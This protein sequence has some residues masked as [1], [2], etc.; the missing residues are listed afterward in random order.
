MGT[1]SMSVPIATSAGRA[2]FGPQLSLTYDSGA[3]NSAFGFGWNLQLPGVTRKT[4]KGLPQYRDAD[5]SDVFI[6]SGAE[7]LVPVYRRDLDGSWT[8]SHGGYQRDDDDWAHDPQ[9]NFVFHEDDLDGYRVRRYCPRIGGLFARIERWSRIGDVSDVHWRSISRDNVLTIYGGDAGSRIFDPDRPDRIFS[10]LACETRDDKGN[11]V[12]YR[13]REEDGGGVGLGRV[14]ERNRGSRDDVRRRANRFI[15]RIHYGNRTTLLDSAGRRPRF[16]DQQQINRQI[17]DGKWMFEVVFDYGDHDPD[18]P[19]PLDNELTKADGTP[20]FPWNFRQDPFSSYRSGFEVRTTRLCRRVLMFHHFADEPVG[21]E[22][23]VRSTDFAYSAAEDPSG[24]SHPVYT[25]LRSVTQT[26]YLRENGAYRSQGLPP[27]E[28]DYTQAVI[29]E[30]VSEVDAAS[31]K[32]LPAGLDDKL[33]RWTDL[34]GEG[35]PGILTEQGGAWF[36]KR[37][38]SPVADGAVELAPLECVTSKP[39]LGLSRDSAQFMDLAGDGQPDLVVFEGPVQG[40]YEHDEDDNGWQSFRPFQS[41]LNRD[42]RDRNLRFVDL[43][44]DGHADVLIT[45]DGAFV[46]HES[47]AERGFGPARRVAQESDEE[48]GPRLVFADGTESI[49]LADLSGDGLSDLVRIRNGEVCYWPNLGYCRFGAKVTMDNAP[50]FDNPEQFDHSRLRLADIDGS[51]TTD[52]IYLH[53]EGVR[54]HFNQSG[55]GWSEPRALQIAP[56]VDDLVNL[57]PADLFGNGT[58]CLVWSSPLPGD[59]PGQMRYVDLMGGQKPHLL[60]VTRNNLGATTEVQYASSTKFYLQDRLAGKPWVTRLAFP[61]HVVEKA[62]VTDVWRNTTFTTTYSYHHGYF[63]GIERE[64]RGFGRVEQIDTEDYGTVAANNAGSPYVSDATLFQPPVK[65]VSWFHT[66]AFLDGERILSQFAHEYFQNPLEAGLPEPDLVSVGRSHQEWREALRSCKGM[67]LRQEVYELDVQALGAGEQRPV[68]LFSAAFH[69]CHIER[70]Q[71]RA[72]NRHAVFLVTESE[73]I[74]YHYE[75]DLTTPTTPDPRATH[76]LN[77]KVDELGQVLQSVAVRYPRFKQFSDAQLSNGT[78]QLIRDVQKELHIAYVETRYTDADIDDPDTYRLRVPCEVQT[79]ELTG[80]GTEDA[81]DG[82]TPDPRDNLYFSIDELRAY[83]LSRRYQ[84][85]GTPVSFLKYH[86]LPDGSPQKRIVEHTRTLYFDDA[87]LAPA[88]AL[89]FGQHGPRGL[90]YEDY[91]LALTKDL[92]AKVFGGRLSESPIPQRTA[93]DLLNDPAV[94]GYW[95]GENFVDKLRD[96][97]WMRSGIAGFAPNAWRHFFLPE[98]YTDP[99]G[100]PTTVSFDTYD[101]LV[102]S[103]QDARDNEV[104][105]VEFDF[106]VLAPAAVRDV[107]ENVTRVAFDIL[108]MPVAMA[109]EAGGDTLGGLTTDLLNPSVLERAT[110]FGLD[111]Y[112]D[113]KPRTWLAQAT[114]RFVYHFGEAVNAFGLVTGWESRPPA[115]C[116]IQRETHVASLNGGKT[117]IQVAVEYSDGMG[118]ILVRKAQ[119]EPDSDSPLQDPPLQWVASG[120]QILNN[121]GKPVK[122]YEPSFSSTEH[123]FDRTEAQQDAG[124]TSITY[125]DAPGRP[126]RVEMPDGTFSRTE[127]S[128]WFVRNFDANDTVSQS[129][130]YRDLGSPAAGAA[131]PADPGMRAAWLALAHDATPS[132]THFDSMGRDVIAIQYNRVEDPASPVVIAG[133]HWRDE[134]YVTFTRFD[135]EGKALWIRDARGH[136][137]MQYISPAKANN[138]PSNDI[139]PGTVPC[140]DV[141]GN[142]LYQYSMDAGER[143]LLSDAAGKPMIAWDRNDQGSGSAKQNR[144]LYTAYDELHRPTAQ[145]ISIDRSPAQQAER[146]EYR[147]ADDGDAAALRNNLQGQLVRHYDPSGLLETVRRD[148]KGNVQEMHRRLDNQPTLSLIDWQ[149]RNP[150]AR[151]SA[152]TFIQIREYDALNRVTVLYNWH[153]DLVAGQASPGQSDRVAVYETTYNARGLLASQTLHIRA[154]KAT[155][156][157]GKIAFAPDAD[158]TMNVEAITR[159][160]WNAKGQQT[161]LELANGTV[162]DYEYDPNTFR[163]V[164]LQT[165]RSSTQTCPA[166]LSSA[167]VDGRVIQD[168]HYA[169]DAVGN[170]TEIRDAAFEVVFFQGQRVEPDNRFVYDAL[171]RLIEASGRENGPSTGAPTNVEAGPLRNLFPCLPNEALRNYTQAYAYDPVGNIQSIQHQA[172]PI[173]NW[174]RDYQYAFDD[175]SQPA[176][177]RLWKTSVGTETVTYRHDAHG[178]MLNLAMTNPRFDMRW[179]YRD[180][181]ESIDLL[182]GGIARYQ[183]DSGKQRTRKLVKRNGTTEE[184]IYLGGFELYRRYSNAN[185]N[186]AVEEIE[187]H[188]LLQGEQRVL[189]AEDVISTDRTHAD[190]RAFATGPIYRYQ[191]SNHLGSATLELDDNAQIISYEEYHPYGTSAYRSMRSDSEASLK[192]YR[193]TGMERDQE[194]GLSYHAARYYLPW[195]ARWASCDPSQLRDGVNRYFSFRGNPTG[196]ADRSGRVAADFADWWEKQDAQTRPGGSGEMQAARRA[197]EIERAANWLVDQIPSGASPQK[198]SFRFQAVGMITTLQEAANIGSGLVAAIDNPSMIA[199]GILRLGTGSAEGANEWDRGDKVSGASKIVVEGLTALTI[200]L[201][202]LGLAR[203]A[204]IPTNPNLPGG[205]TNALN[206]AAY[207][208]FEGAVADSAQGPLNTSATQVTIQPLVEA[209]AGEIGPQVLPARYKVISGTRQVVTSGGQDLTFRVDAVS[210]S[211][212]TDLLQWDEAKSSATAP[213]TQSQAAG[214]PLLEDVGGI[215]KAHNAGAVGLPYGSVLG[216]QGAINIVRPLDLFGRLLKPAATAA[217]STAASDAIRDSQRQ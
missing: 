35:I 108:G 145:W 64:F 105:V 160:D 50:W 23:L 172:G 51:G 43:D 154:S 217:T 82:L 123:R 141:A 38:L 132:Q 4:D 165:R 114:S 94:S 103:T 149:G 75:L 45:E 211:S 13:Y 80:I 66:G 148:F 102:E 88:G 142:L 121:K 206:R 46:W 55:N 193:Y 180:M 196:Y 86:E 115:A 104:E 47:L 147:D 30:A 175:A 101:L 159:I 87:G 158:A 194:S 146:F 157:N 111:P 71:P 202:G 33:Y 99:F 67:L 167:F 176:S 76:T 74:T 138:D 117:A 85:S 7:D 8:A 56:R 57:V 39:N 212:L 197:A 32:N 130:W 166:N 81:S 214:F 19:T 29:Q 128:P 49:Y 44:G 100:K 173:G 182:G 69:N 134:R 203:A 179:D 31:L 93:R 52:I 177:N 215:V 125:Y 143:W 170:I 208:R 200:V 6:L 155:D 171:Y 83:R 169:Y 136:L 186:V 178:N 133:R 21:A 41:R 184:R 140:Y 185:P 119:A 198:D 126:I 106:R 34:H 48:Q 151:L 77:L 163:L 216:P 129:R 22:C 11:G 28:F 174:T 150:A 9:G 92:L 72:A 10:W 73:A 37:N 14:S 89:P 118:N 60:K 58:A 70:L 152:E 97:W 109:M 62:T 122:Q 24:V 16:L 3:G 40:F 42:T 12:L 90:K 213:L 124:V 113:L 26:G 107:N 63:D 25:Y 207:V 91:K 181:L 204:M 209:P 65:T 53:R 201:G 135:A 15:K 79:Y 144:L 139:Q 110:F 18:A 20:R 153:R 183:Y 187:S 127:F 68:K 78:V 195:I 188:H 156:A 95:P 27:V 61:V 5:E 112:S 161:L 59:A 54:L 2:G 162:T 137:V 210:R 131:E 189:L 199:R 164:N 191:Y 36:Y 98:R 17:V 205:I 168:L 84:T 1:G 120:K 96:Q 190:G 192:R 116:S